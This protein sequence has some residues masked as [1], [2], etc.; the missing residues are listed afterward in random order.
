MSSFLKCDG[1][2]F[3]VHLLEERQTVEWIIREL[4]M[5]DPMDAGRI[6]KPSDAR[7]QKEYHVKG[8][9]HRNMNF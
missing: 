7:L 1:I 4:Q 8:S 6:R 5:V 9:F 2:F 3:Q